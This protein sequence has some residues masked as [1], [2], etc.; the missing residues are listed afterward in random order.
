MSP[1]VAACCHVHLQIAA[2][3]AETSTVQNFVYLCMLVFDCK[4]DACLMQAL[5]D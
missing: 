4:G 1:T 3:V 5:L 2:Q